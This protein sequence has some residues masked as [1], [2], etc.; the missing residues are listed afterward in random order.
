MVHVRVCVLGP[1]WPIKRSP[2][3]GPRPWL[4]PAAVSSRG[5]KHVPAWP[6]RHA[7]PRCEIATRATV[8]QATHPVCRHHGAVPSFPSLFFCQARLRSA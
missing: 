2:R 6:V 4:F 8:G 5:Q 7:T 3:Y 1:S